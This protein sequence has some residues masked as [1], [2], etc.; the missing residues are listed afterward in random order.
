MS[1][2]EQ[3]FAL[4]IEFHRRLRQQTLGT[5]EI[6]ALHTSYALQSGYEQLLR[7]MGR[8]TALEIRQL[9]DRSTVA[10]DPRDVLKARH[11]VARLLGLRPFET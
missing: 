9:A 1:P 4:E 5:A 6:T 11:S 2:L 8:V 3:L 10:G 7:G